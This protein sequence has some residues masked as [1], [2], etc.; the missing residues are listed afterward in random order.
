MILSWECL[1]A[2][3]EPEIPGQVFHGFFVEIIRGC[4]WLRSKVRAAT[5][6]AHDG[7][8]AW[9]PGQYVWPWRIF[10]LGETKDLEYERAIVWHSDR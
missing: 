6:I 5:R 9:W 7:L 4:V 8:V 10:V 3:G 2:I 1:L